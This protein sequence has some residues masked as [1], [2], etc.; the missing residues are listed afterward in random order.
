MCTAEQLTPKSA[1]HIT[2]AMSIGMLGGAVGARVCFVVRRAG[3]T[4]TNSKYILQAL[5]FAPRS[6][7]SEAVQNTCTGVYKR[8][9][10]CVSIS[11]MAHKAV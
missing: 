4:D 7:E 9:Q 5:T 11:E 1:A 2:A 8:T 10:T 6:D 3:T